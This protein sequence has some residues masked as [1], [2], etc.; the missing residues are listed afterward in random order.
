[1]EVLQE[2]SSH[3]NVQDTCTSSDSE[4]QDMT[5]SK[6]D[7]PV[8]LEPEKCQTISSASE[9]ETEKNEGESLVAAMPEKQDCI[10]QEISDSSQVETEGKSKYVSACWWILI[11]TF[12]L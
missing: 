4:D 6:A 11:S 9:L 7:D 2:S 1:M 5:V 8:N 3:D 12:F 10:T